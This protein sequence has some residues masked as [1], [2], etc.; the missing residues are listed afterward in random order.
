M[1]NSRE[2]ATQILNNI[3]T[4]F[5]FFETA[6]LQNKSFS[7]LDPRDKAF[8]RSIILNTL[9]RNGQI[10]NVIND[11]VRRP[12]KK[13]D[14]FILNLIRISI[15]QILFLEIKEYSIVNS[16]VQIA[17]NYKFDKF[18]NGLLRNICRNKAK[19]LKNQTLEV[20]IPN[21]IKKDI[22]VNLGKNALKEISR[23]VIKEPYLDIKIKKNYLGTQDGIK[24]GIKV[25]NELLKR[26]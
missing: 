22:S 14:V 20:N 4:R 15:C 17:K 5:E 2:I 18:V 6:M 9:R 23:T 21:W 13:K 26:A 25:A 24:S 19:I 8:V 12:L 3:Y 11:F 1:S 7:R 16:A 10:T